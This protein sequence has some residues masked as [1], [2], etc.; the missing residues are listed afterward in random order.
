MEILLI[1]VIVGLM[2]FGILYRVFILV[3]AYLWV[4]QSSLVLAIRMKMGATL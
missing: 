3:V 1:F 2:M 4:V